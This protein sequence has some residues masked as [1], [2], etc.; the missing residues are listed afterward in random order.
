MCSR[1]N[2]DFLILYQLTKNVRIKILILINK[3]YEKRFESSCSRKVMYLSKNYLK[4][5]EPFSFF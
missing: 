5:F 3:M 1:D 2:S 4:I